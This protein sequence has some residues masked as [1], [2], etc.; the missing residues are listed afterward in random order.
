LEVASGAVQITAPN[1]GS[2]IP[3]T[4]TTGQVVMMQTEEA[5]TQVSA[6]RDTT[7]NHIVA[8]DQ[9]RVEY[10]ATPPAGG[11]PTTVTVFSGEAVQ[12][13][14]EGEL[15]IVRF[16]SLD[17]RGDRPGDFLPPPSEADPNLQT[18]Q[19][20]GFSQRFNEPIENVVN[21]VLANQLGLTP[22]GETPLQQSTSGVITYTTAQGTLRIIPIGNVRIVINPSRV[23]TGDIAANLAEIV[24]EGIALAV[25]PAT[26]MGDLN[27][28]L[29]ALEGDNPATLQ[30]N[31]VITGM[32][33]GQR[34]AVQPSPVVA[35]SS[36]DLTPGFVDQNGAPAL[37]DASGNI[38]TLYP[39]FADPGQVQTIFRSL[40]PRMTIG[41]NYDG[42]Y[43]VFI[44][45]TN[46]TLVPDFLLGS[47]GPA[48]NWWT[49]GGKFFV[50]YSDGATQG[51]QLR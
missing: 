14:K 41:N 6:G 18:P 21:R 31:G 51:F 3:V 35:A 22:S 24:G 7:Q 44:A 4:S 48:E 32:L 33:N 46:L 25:A 28:A 30:A 29:R 36:L 10:V 47:G 43:R 38:Q 8:I 49:E 50:R 1:V 20:T 19:I 45:D 42:S 40:D 5:N 39:A 37:R 11:T 16:G 12:V 13:T 2:K 23:A 26:S 17:Q 27:A 15:S 9:G 34:Y